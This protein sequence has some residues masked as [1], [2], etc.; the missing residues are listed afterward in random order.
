MTTPGWHQSE[1]HKCYFFNGATCSQQGQYFTP[2]IDTFFL[3]I[4]KFSQKKNKTTQLWVSMV[5]LHCNV[6]IL[7]RLKLEKD[8]IGLSLLLRMFSKSVR[9]ITQGLRFLF[10]CGRDFCSTCSGRVKTASHLHEHEGGPSIHLM[11]IWKSVQLKRNS[12]AVAETASTDTQLKRR[13]I[14]IG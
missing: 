11:L 8:P 10:Q 3:M 2:N 13:E 4:T 6:K 1:V 14:R 7:H 9:G 5:K 12:A